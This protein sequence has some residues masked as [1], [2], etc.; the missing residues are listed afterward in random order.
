[1]HNPEPVFLDA[2]VLIYFLDET[3]GVHDEVVHTLQSLVD[4]GVDLYTSHHV[5]EEVLFII[6]RLSTSKT[7]LATAVR[8]IAAIPNLSLVEP[9]AEFSFAERYVRLYKSSKVG[10]N[11]TLLLQLV[12]DAGI[13]RV[14]SYDEKLQKQ[15]Q[16]LGIKPVKL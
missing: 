1:M 10:I 12:L 8:Q 2:N 16:S 5:L 4:E 7:V 9:L 6:S 13:G 15:A 3:A 14:F 11:D